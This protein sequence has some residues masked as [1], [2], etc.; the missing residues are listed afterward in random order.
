[1]A[2]LGVGVLVVDDYLVM[3]QVMRSLLQRIGFKNIDDA[4]DGGTALAKLRDNRFGLVISDWNMGSMSGL[5]LLKEVRAD[6]R[7]KEMPF[8]MVTGES[9]DENA[10]AAKEAGVSNYI[11]KPFDAGTLKAKIEAVLGSL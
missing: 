6:S 9:T 7:L 3:R 4:G 2:D 11:V 1:M 8:I 5:Q 10:V